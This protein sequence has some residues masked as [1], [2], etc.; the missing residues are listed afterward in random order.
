MPSISKGV[1]D[2]ENGISRQNGKFSNQKPMK[3]KNESIT[4][5]IHSEAVTR[6]RKESNDE[7]ISM[8][9]LLNKILKNHNDWHSVASKAGFI[10]VRRVLLRTLIDKLS[11]EEVKM[12]AAQIAITTNRDFLMILR[13]KVSVESAIDYVE[14]WL[15][16]SGFIYRHQSNANATGNYSFV[17]QHDMGKKWSLYLGELYK[18]LFEEC[19]ASRFFYDSR[20]NMLS[21]TVEV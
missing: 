21:F 11:E 3:S 7:E 4:F 9:T 16:T 2:E 8:N 12:L 20:D 10:A 14:S 1:D 6:L 15:R 17:I 19:G 18:H 13:N 5:R